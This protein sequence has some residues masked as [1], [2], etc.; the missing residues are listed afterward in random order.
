MRGTWESGKCPG[1]QVQFQKTPGNNRS[2]HLYR[3]NK[4]YEDTIGNPNRDRPNAVIKPGKI[5]DREKDAS[6]HIID[7]E[8]RRESLKE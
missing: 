7:K 6:Y 1:Y 5:I 3:L 4:M 2:G 8:D